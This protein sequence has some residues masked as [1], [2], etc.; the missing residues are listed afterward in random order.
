M[1][2]YITEVHGFQEENITM[3]MDDGIHTAPTKANIL[4]AFSNLV[5]QCQPGDAVFCHYAG[6]WLHEEHSNIF[7]KG[8]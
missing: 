6:E 7:V 3:L 5:K 4:K 2:T 1:K 8:F